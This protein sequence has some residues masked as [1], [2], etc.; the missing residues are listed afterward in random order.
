MRRFQVVYIML[1]LLTYVSSCSNQKRDD[2]AKEARNIEV[3]LNDYLNKVI[4]LHGIPGLALGIVQDDTL[5]YKTYLGNAS[6]E[7]DTQVDEKTLFRV[8]STTKL[9][10][11]TA[12]F[13]LV[14]Q[15]KITLDDKIS[16]YLEDFPEQWRHITIKNLLTHSSGLPDFIR[17]DSELSDT[18]IIE[19]M[20]KAEMSFETGNQFQYNQTNYWF[21]SKIVEKVTNTAFEDF[22][23]Q[24]QFKDAEGQVLFSSNSNDKIK[25]RATRYMYNRRTETFEQDTNNDRKRGHAG[26]GLN[27]TLSEFVKWNLRLDTGELLKVKT[28]DVMWSPFPFKNGTDEFLNGWGIYKTNGINSYGFTGGNLSAFRKFP[29][30]NTTIVLLSNGYKIPAYDIIINDI[31][32]IVLPELKDKELVLE[33][34]IMELLKSKN[35]KDAEVAYTKLKSENEQT[36]FSNLKWNIN[37]MSRIFSSEDDEQAFTSLVKFNAKMNPEWWVAAVALAEVFEANNQKEKAIANY[38]KAIKL[39]T[40]NE[41][42]YNPRI[43]EVMEALRKK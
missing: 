42:N 38:E 36:D 33:E 2:K 26:N 30:Q 28:K 9:I 10:T 14:E 22:V 41:G 17:Y 25:G 20:A 27:I 5:I 3:Q 11:A 35:F 40:A 34:Q 37:T 13:Q 8:F 12:I 16:Y 23:L 43:Q 19:E 32:R 7:E 18:N 21:L 24:H 29:N 31:A 39:N 6:I 1:A 15:Q 4:E